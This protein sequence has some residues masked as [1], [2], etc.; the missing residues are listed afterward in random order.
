MLGESSLPLFM[1]TVL[2]YNLI[3]ITII[4]ANYLLIFYKNRYET[5]IVKYPEVKSKFLPLLLYHII[6]LIIMMVVLAFEIF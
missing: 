4:I 5:I 2:I 3:I 1:N 6:S